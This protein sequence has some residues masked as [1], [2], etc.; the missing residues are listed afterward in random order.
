[1]LRLGAAVRVAARNVDA[2]RAAFG[3]S[4]EVVPFDYT[5]PA[6][7][8]AFAGI[9]RMFLLRPPTIADVD[10]VIAPALDAARERRVRAA[11]FLSIQGAVRNRLVPHRAIEEHLR[12]TSWSWT[13]IRAAYFMQN[14]ATT[15]AP[16]IRDL[17]AI[18]IPA[19]RGRASGT[20]SAM[21]RARRSD[22]PAAARWTPVRQ[23]SPQRTLGRQ[24]TLHEPPGSGITA[25]PR[26]IMR[27]SGP[28][29]G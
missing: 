26:T 24:R 29:G 27:E 13:F 3:E 19:G 18:M 5:D 28:C 20:S 2:A 8:D 4:A 6:T 15:H 10:R 7:F 25:L 12:A 14:L 1:M 22:A 21:G 17:D 11:V 23:M 16:G 9:D